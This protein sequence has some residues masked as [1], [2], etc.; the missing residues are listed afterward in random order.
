MTPATGRSEHFHAVTASF[1]GWTLDAFDFFLVVFALTDIAKEFGATDADD[2]VRD[3]ADAGDAAASA[4][5]S[6]D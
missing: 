3:H 5:S 2:G 4:R 1:L 6:S